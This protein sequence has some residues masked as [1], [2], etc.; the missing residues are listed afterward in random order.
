MSSRYA[1]E[2]KIPFFG[3]CLGMQCAVIDFAR[4]E[5]KMKAANSTEFSDRT[6]FPV[7][8]L[9]KA[10]KKIS[11]KGASMRLGSY[12]CNITSGTKAHS[13]YRKKIIHERHRHR[14]EFNNKYKKKLTSAGMIISGKN[15]ELNL[16][17]MI[18]LSN[19]PW[20]VGVQFHP[21]VKSTLIKTHPLFNNFIEASVKFRDDQ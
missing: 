19:H 6:K 14:Y 7:I 21:E 5:C 1:R 12:S 3:I 10:Q 20:F 2:Q 8:D 13:A 4:H 18:E 16:V 9:M 11:Y 17:E 15:E